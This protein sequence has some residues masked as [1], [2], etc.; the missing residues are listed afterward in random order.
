MLNARAISIRHQTVIGLCVVIFGLLLAWEIGEWI[1]AGNLIQVAY[2]AVAAAVAVVSLGILRNWRS[3]VY[4]FLIWLVFEDL[5]R[6][7]LGNNMAIFFAKDVLAAL[8]YVS[9]IRAIG[10]HQEKAFRLPFLFAISLFFWCAAL[11]IFNPNSPSPLYGALGFKIY[12]FYVPFIFAGYALVRNDQDLRRIL[13]VTPSVAAVVAGI[14][15][16]QAVVGPQFLNPATL[17]PEIRELAAL[18]KVTPITQ[19]IFHLPSSVFVS[20]GRYGQYLFVL[21]GSGDGRRWL[22]SAARRARQTVSNWFAWRDRRGRTLLWIARCP[23]PECGLA[24]AS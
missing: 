2:L 1:V 20:A 6:K 5:V 14:G 22:F 15:I 23:H 4:M 7:Y 10:N 19:Q 17:A 8:I 18:D 11:Q 21:C 13:I 24:P 16:I 12:F 9:I 3:G